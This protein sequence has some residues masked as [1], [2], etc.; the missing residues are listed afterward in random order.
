MDIRFNQQPLSVTLYG[1]REEFRDLALGAELGLSSYELIPTTAK[2]GENY[3]SNPDLDFY[4]AVKD[5]TGKPVN[6]VRRTPHGIG[7]A[8]HNKL[9]VNLT[10]DEFELAVNAAVRV[11]DYYREKAPR[12]VEGAAQLR[13]QLE[14][15]RQPASQ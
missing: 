3:T 9:F 5:Y 10:F 13:L 8:N 14:A 11:T 15:A 6:R 12:L 7:V 1:A 4:N 2:P